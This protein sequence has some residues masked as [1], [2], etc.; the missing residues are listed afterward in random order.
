M[1]SKIYPI[2]L[3]LLISIQFSCEKDYVEPAGL[4]DGYSFE[5][6]PIQFSSF[7][8]FGDDYNLSWT[9]EDAYDGEGSLRMESGR[10]NNQSFAFWNLSYT[11]F[12]VG[13]PFKVKVRVKT[14]VMQGNGGVQ[15]NMF[16]RSK[17]RNSNITSGI[18]EQISST[19][20]EWQTIE[21][22]LDQPPTDAVGNIDIYFLFLTGSSGTSYWDKL[23]IYTG[24]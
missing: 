8:S 9:Q 13:Q 15:V 12:V 16:A 1:K 4:L 6:D 11:D 24:E 2:F 10:N 3:L 5:T 20:G 17:D 19:N 7:S 22:S 21:V 18:G 23:E 14:V